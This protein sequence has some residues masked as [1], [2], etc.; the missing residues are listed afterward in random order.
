M[1]ETFATFT[2]EGFARLGLASSV[3]LGI[4]AEA[5]WHLFNLGDLHS[6]NPTKIK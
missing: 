4:D 1:I 2:S 5:T 6:F 3:Y